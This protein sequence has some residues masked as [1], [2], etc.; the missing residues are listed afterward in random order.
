MLRTL[1]SVAVCSVALFA[2]A[3]ANPV[4]KRQASGDSAFITINSGG[5][6]RDYLLSVPA[7]YTGSSAV[8]LI[9]SFHGRGEDATYQ[10]KLTGLS[11]PA[12]NPNAIVAYPNGVA[13]SSRGP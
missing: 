2:N 12:V 9:F 11:N 3:S 13:V 7:S 6:S 10:Q 8:P 1:F 5:L 4:V